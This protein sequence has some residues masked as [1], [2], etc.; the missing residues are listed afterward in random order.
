MRRFTTSAATDRRRVGALLVAE[1]ICAL[2]LVGR[3]QSA[4]ARPVEAAPASLTT[5]TASSTTETLDDGRTVHLVG[6]GGSHTAPLLTR[7]AAQMNDAAKAVSAFWGPDWPRDIVIVAAGSDA[8]FGSLAGGGPDTAATTTAERIMFAPG[9]VAMSDASLRIVLRHELFHFASRADTAAD[10]PRWLTEGV[11]DFVGRPP[12]P[13]P[14]NAAELA[15]I[16][17]DTD[18]NTAGPAGSAAYDR[19]WWFS[20]FVADAYGTATLRALYLRAC[21]PGHPDAA[22]A[23]RDTLGADLPTVLARWRHWMSG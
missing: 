9:A 16:P 23:V 14:A 18:L 5:P 17:T 22:T 21:S 7:I 1:L 13:P 11:A 12:T 15:T 3:P 6:L 20:R 2:F 10:A 4:P 8:Q 19:A